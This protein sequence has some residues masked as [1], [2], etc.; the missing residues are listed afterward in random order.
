MWKELASFQVLSHMWLMATMLDSAGSLQ[1]DL[2][3]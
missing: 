3:F 2:E 1:Y